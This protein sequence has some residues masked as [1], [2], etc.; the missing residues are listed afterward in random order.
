M[1]PSAS[2][3]LLSTACAL[4]LGGCFALKPPGPIVSS[5]SLDGI[6]PAAPV[7]V[8]TEQTTALEDVRKTSSTCPPGHAS[9]SPDCVVTHYTVTEPVSRTTTTMIAG[10]H[11]LTY[12]QFLTLTESDRPQRVSELGDKT[13]T[14]NRARIPR[15][16]S[17]G[18]G[19]VGV[20]LLVYGA[21]QGNKPLT[22]TGAGVSAAALGVGAG[23]LV[24]AK[25]S[26]R[27]ARS[28]AESLDLS[29]RDQTTVRGAEAAKEIRALADEHN[30]RSPQAVR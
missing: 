13:K 27:E 5:A 30:R 21:T 29:G 16:V 26:C 18:L 7:E 9:G 23:A 28:L 1:K 17:V 24:M 25:G 10:S 12:A 11:Q 14:C 4:L 8:E 2:S 3:S 19:V 20:S 6:D 22:Y 15:Y